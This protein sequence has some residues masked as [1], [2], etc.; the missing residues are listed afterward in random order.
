MT[1]S[2]PPDLLLHWLM[3]A[4]IMLTLASCIVPKVHSLP[5]NLKIGGLFASDEQEQEAVFKFAI[6]KVN[7]DPNLLQTSTLSPVIEKI[8]KNDSFHTDKKGKAAM[9]G[10]MASVSMIS[11]SVAKMLPQP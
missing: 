2:R 11:E 8:V 7:S 4:S 1:R 5:A 3:Q 6:S 9:Q 10:L